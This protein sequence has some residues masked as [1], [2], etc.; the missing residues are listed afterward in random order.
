MCVY[1]MCDS[2]LRTRSLASSSASWQRR[3]SASKLCCLFLGWGGGV[4]HSEDILSL[5]VE[6][7]DRGGQQVNALCGE[8]YS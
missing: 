1:N 7:W 5:H 4:W 6:R 2:Y 3:S 8:V